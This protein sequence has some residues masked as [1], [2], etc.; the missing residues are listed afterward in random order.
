MGRGK[1]KYAIL[2]T[3][4][5]QSDP[6]TKKLRRLEIIQKRKRKREKQ[7]S[8]NNENQIKK[9]CLD[10]MGPVCFGF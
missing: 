4:N 1:R 10:D 8:N 7:N 5:I 9:C 3:K 2:D 6:E